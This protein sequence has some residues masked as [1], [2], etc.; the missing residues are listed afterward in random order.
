MVLTTDLF[1]KM[2]SGLQKNN[3]YCQFRWA[4]KHTD[5]YFSES[6]AYKSETNKSKKFT[7]NQF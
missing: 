1:N 7:K 3:Y 4:Q 2:N 6:T 5:V